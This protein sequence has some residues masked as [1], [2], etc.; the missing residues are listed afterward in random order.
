MTVVIVFLI[1]IMNQI[2]TCWT[3]YAWPISLLLMVYE[4][5]TCNFSKIAIIQNFRS[6]V[7]IEIRY[8][9]PDLITEEANHSLKA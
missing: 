9:I 8:T 1:K 3:N 2:I 7:Y 6:V 5:R 4:Q